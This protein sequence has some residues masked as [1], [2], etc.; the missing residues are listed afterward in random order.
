MSTKVVILLIHAGA[1]VLLLTACII[2]LDLWLML[3]DILIITLC[4][5]A[6]FQNINYYYD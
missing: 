5:V 1:Y 3:L 2:Y 6:S 4:A